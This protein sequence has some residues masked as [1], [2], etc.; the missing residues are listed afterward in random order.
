MDLLDIRSVEL[1]NVW[2]K[3]VPVI[4]ASGG[5]HVTWNF[6][7][8]IQI[9]YRAFEEVTGWKFVKAENITRL[10]FDTQEERDEE[11]ILEKISNETDSETVA[12]IGSSKMY[13]NIRGSFKLTV[14]K[15]TGSGVSMKFEIKR[16]KIMSCVEQ[17]VTLKKGDEAVKY[18][19]VRYRVLFVYDCNTYNFEDWKATCDYTHEIIKISAPIHSVRKIQ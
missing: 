7:K 5:G 18:V 14:D 16:K 13:D 4:L 1:L 15:I 9:N 11:V 6:W 8:P 19:A 3:M 2:N 10:Y 12:T 17:K